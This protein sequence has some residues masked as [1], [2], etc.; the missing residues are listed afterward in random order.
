MIGLVWTRGYTFDPPGFS[1]RSDAYLAEIK[2][3]IKTGTTG[4]VDMDN[5]EGWVDIG[6]LRKSLDRRHRHREMSQPPH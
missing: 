4:P 5:S 1:Q 2:I 6:F 3:R